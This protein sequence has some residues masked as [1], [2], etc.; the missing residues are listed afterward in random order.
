[1]SQ[2]QQRLDIK[3]PVGRIVGGSVSEGRTTDFEGKPLVYKT[4]DKAGQPR[5]DFSFGIAIAKTQAH[6]GNE[7]GWGQQIWQF[8]NGAWGGIAQRADF[9]W[10][11]EDGDSQ[12]PNKKGNKPCD[13]EGYPGHWVIWFSGAQRPKVCDAKGQRFLSEEEIAAIKAGFYVQVF[14]NVDSNGSQGN[15][16]LYINHNIVSFQ[17]GGQEIQLGVDIASIG[18]GSDPL[19]AG[20]TAIPAGV[21]GDQPGVASAP[22]AAPPTPAP[23]ASATPA[24]PVTTAVQPHT[25]ILNAGAAPAPTPAAPMPPAPPAPVAASPQMTAAAQ[26][27]YEAYK[28]AGWTDDQLRQNGLML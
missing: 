21:P 16:G 1:M 4:G 10:K 13:R 27:T 14:G 22:V 15:P 3:F 9:S 12:I 8:G 19:P 28:A 11:I 18:F 20:A 7:P 24:P 26:T 17:A 5:K 2:N 23:P 25:A 6:W